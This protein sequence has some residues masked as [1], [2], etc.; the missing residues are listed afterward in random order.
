[1][2][3]LEKWSGIQTL[4]QG[5]TGTP[6]AVRG[7]I[8]SLYGLHMKNTHAHTR[9]HKILCYCA[10]KVADPHNVLCSYVFNCCQHQCNQECL[11]SSLSV[12]K[13]FSPDQ[14][15]VWW[16][17]CGELASCRGPQLTP[18]IQSGTHLIS[19]NSRE[20]TKCTNING[21]LIEVVLVPRRGFQPLKWL[22]CDSVWRGNPQP[23]FA[24]LCVTPEKMTTISHN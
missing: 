3:M 17:Y 14:P 7:I 11:N 12:F 22:T 19:S 5:Q 23:G 21:G 16:L 24:I 8:Y 1:M 15:S 2:L 18:I 13:N 10:Q 20:T 4:S 9:E 6:E